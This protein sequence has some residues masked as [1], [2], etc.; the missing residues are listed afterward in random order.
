MAGKKIDISCD[1]GESFGLW[2]LG[3]D[4][5]MVDYITSANVACGYHAGDP[6]VMRDTV[7][8]CAAKGVRVGAHVG[9]PDLM[10]F[11]RRPMHCKHEE[12]RDFLVYQTGAL[13]L[14]L[15]LAGEQLQHVKPHGS[16]YMMAAEDEALSRVIL[17]TVASIG[18]D[19]PVYCMRDSVTYEVGK[20]IGVPVVAEFYADRGMRDNGQI[21][22][23]YDIAN[24]GGSAEA[25][26]ARAV[27]CLLEGKV[28]SNESGI[29]VELQPDSVCV[30]GDTPQA[31]EFAVALRKAFSEAGIEA[32]PLAE[33]FAG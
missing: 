1:M 19:L 29:D 33:Y 30:H 31:I 22:F 18:R 9:F 16:L 25:M 24:V 7:E 32:A 14:F 21:I 10:G 26:A 3:R 13:R 15:E 4:E 2:K 8:R 23:T 27:R 17:E 28:R 11:G 20:R 12:V 5:E 6:R